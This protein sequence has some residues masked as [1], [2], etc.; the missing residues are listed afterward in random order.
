MAV[1]A[2]LPSKLF[3]KLTDF[4]NEEILSIDNIVCSNQDEIP[5]A[6]YAN[7]HFLLMQKPW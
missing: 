7:H 5:N 2:S 1:A 3:H 6:I 4:S